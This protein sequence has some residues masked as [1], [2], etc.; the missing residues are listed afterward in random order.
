MT[1]YRPSL[2]IL[3][4]EHGE[5]KRIR[6]VLVLRDQ[7]AGPVFVM[8]E[9]KT[10]EGLVATPLTFEPYDGITIQHSAHEM[11]YLLWQEPIWSC[12]TLHLCLWHAP[13]EAAHLPLQKHA[14]RKGD[15][16]YFASR[17]A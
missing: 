2:Q 13:L 15:I 12:K 17:A 5:T 3:N 7:T 4:Q 1:T 10:W 11:N 6:L 16:T 8:F 9:K 14:N